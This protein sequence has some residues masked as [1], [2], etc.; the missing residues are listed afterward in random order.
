MVAPLWVLVIL[1]L[2]DGFRV[3]DPTTE[4]YASFEPYERGFVG[5]VD[6]AENWMP[7]PVPYF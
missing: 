5:E 6:N 2:S 4:E 1:G 7:E 3:F